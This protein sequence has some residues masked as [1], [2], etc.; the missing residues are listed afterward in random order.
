MKQTRLSGSRL[1]NVKR[2]SPPFRSRRRGAIILIVMVCLLLISMIGASLLKLA[3]AQRKQSRREQLRLQAAWLAESGVERAAVKLVADSK[4]SGETW[5]LKADEL[6]AGR[7]GRVRIEVKPDDRNSNRHVV[8][9]VADFPSNTEQR[10]R[11]SKRV[12]MD[13]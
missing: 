3:T 9:V 11:V 1:R 13:H 5:E 8:S 4:Y 10:A 7:P 2:D 6:G 12:F